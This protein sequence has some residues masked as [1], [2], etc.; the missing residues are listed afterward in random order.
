MKS[1]RNKKVY[2]IDMQVHQSHEAGGAKGPR[3]PHLFSDCQGF[4]NLHGL[5]VGYRQ[6]WVWYRF[7][8]PP[9]TKQALEHPKRIGI[10]GD[11]AQTVGNTV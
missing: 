9:P 2:V 6:V 1:V 5:R 3:A 10:S 11:M 7:L 8:H 4:W